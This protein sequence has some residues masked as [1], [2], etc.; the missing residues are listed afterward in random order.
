MNPKD[1]LPIEEMSRVERYCTSCGEGF[2]GYLSHAVCRVC[3]EAGF[4]G[5]EVES[6][7]AGVPPVEVS[8]PIETP[9]PDMDF[10]YTDEDVAR[11][12]VVYGELQPHLESALNDAF[13][14]GY[15]KGRASRGSDTREPS[16]LS[17]RIAAAINELSRENHSDTPDFI[18]GEG[19]EDILLIIEQVVK[20]RD[21]WYGRDST[22]QNARSVSE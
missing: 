10:D 19:L 21:V 17:K 18:L 8:G 22:C 5:N 13:I 16:E 15:K 7:P 2:L 11:A 4:Q 6:P 14:D 1:Q 3:E 12:R 20:R 9:D